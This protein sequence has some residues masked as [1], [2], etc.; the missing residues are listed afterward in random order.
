MIAVIPAF[1]P[2]RR[3]FVRRPLEHSRD[4]ICR[5]VRGCLGHAWVILAAPVRVVAGIARFRQVRL[6][7]VVLARNP[8]SWPNPHDSLGKQSLLPTPPL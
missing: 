1:S 6:R 2:P 7:A 8:G 4:W 5:T 3:R